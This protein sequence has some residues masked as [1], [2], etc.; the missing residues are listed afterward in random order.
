MKSQ[1]NQAPAA[2]EMRDALVGLACGELS[3]YE[4]HALVAK[5]LQNPA[6]AAQAKLALRLS[7]QA[8][9]T[10]STLVQRADS[11]AANK[12][13]FAWGFR[14]LAGGTC[15]GLL[16]FFAL[17]NPQTNSPERSVVANSTQAAVPE[18][19]M[20]SSGFEAAASDFSSDFGGSF[21]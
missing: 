20:S 16:M 5:I 9:Q 17:P 7:D 15:A 4:R 2:L 1:L 8:T 3:L 18:Q 12:R 19:M 13:S 21:E 10:A 11:I 6:A 14:A